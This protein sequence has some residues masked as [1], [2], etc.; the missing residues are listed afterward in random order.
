MSS[1]RTKIIC[2]GT[3][4]VVLSVGDTVL[5][6]FA[7]TSPRKSMRESMIPFPFGTRTGEEKHDEKNSFELTLTQGR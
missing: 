6:A 7:S 3:H 5:L 1:V 4:P 2:F